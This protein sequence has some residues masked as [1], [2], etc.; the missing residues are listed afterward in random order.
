MDMPQLSVNENEIFSGSEPRDRRNC[1]TRSIRFDLL[2]EVGLPVDYL[3]LSWIRTIASRSI[4]KMVASRELA[5]RVINV[6]KGATRHP[7]GR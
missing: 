6:D 1:A 5:R 3:A 7:H 4:S 2:I